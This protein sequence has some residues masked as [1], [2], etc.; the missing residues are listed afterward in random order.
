MMTRHS[1]RGIALPAMVFL[2]VVIGL[3]VA[4]GLS[5]SLQST[6]SHA[7]QLQT[8]RA[9][10]AARSALEWGLWQVSDAQ[11]SLGLAPDTAPACFGP[12]TLTL[13]APLGDFS[14]QVTCARTPASGQIDDGGLKLASYAIVAVATQGA[15]SDP[16]HVR[17]Q[18]E[19]RHTVCKN[20]GGEAPAFRC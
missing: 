6:Q 11:G 16:L 1:G 18:M 14:V 13:P 15:T 20:P 8:A 12:T 9:A 4:G 3:L 7:Q 5:L 10:A 19:A 17:R 2:L